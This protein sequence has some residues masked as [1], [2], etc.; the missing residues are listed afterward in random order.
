MAS[1]SKTL[2]QG[3][4]LFTSPTL[5]EAA[6]QTGQAV[7]PTSPLSAA[8]TGASKDAS[9]MVGTPAQT[10]GLS[11]V[12][13]SSPKNSP[14]AAPTKAP[15]GM[16]LQ[17]PET[18]LLDWQDKIKQDPRQLTAVEQD[19]RRQAEEMNPQLGAF[20]G[21]VAQLSVRAAF[22]G[23]QG[24]QVQ[25]NAPA[26]SEFV[27]S[28][29]S[30]REST[31]QIRQEDFTKD[32]A[33]LAASPGNAALMTKMYD[34]Y[35]IDNPET[36]AELL[37]S[38]G[39]TEAAERILNPEAVTM[40]KVFSGMSPEQIQTET[41]LSTSEL[42]KTFGKEWKSLTW[43]AMKDT[44]A[45][46][47][48]AATQTREL[49]NILNNPYIGAAQRSDARK[50]LVELGAIGVRTAEEKINNLK[51]QVEDGD[52]LVVDGKSYE[53]SEI[54]SD[55]YLSSK[56]TEAA[57]DDVAL[58]KLK[59]WAPEV[60]DWLVKNRDSLKAATAQVSDSLKTV[61]ED[62]AYNTNL[63]TITLGNGASVTLDDNLMKAF[64]PEWGTTVTGKMQIED[65]VYKTITSMNDADKAVITESLNSIAKAA[66]PDQLKEYMAK[67]RASGNV[68]NYFRQN[69]F[70]DPARVS[71]MVEKAHDLATID[72]SFTENPDAF[73]GGLFA[74][75][76]AALTKNGTF[77]EVLKSLTTD[78]F[79]MKGLEAAGL[80]H[81]F[82]VNGDGKLSLAD[83]SDK[84]KIF[85]HLK[86]YMSAGGI[87]SGTTLS[88]LKAQM[89]KEVVLGRQIATEMQDD[90]KLNSQASKDITAIGN[91][92]RGFASKMEIDT[93]VINSALKDPAS[94]NTFVNKA[95]AEFKKRIMAYRP[96]TKHIDKNFDSEINAQVELYKRNLESNFKSR[97]NKL[98]AEKDAAYAD[99]LRKEEAQSKKLQATHKGE[100]K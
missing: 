29:N 66:S 89:G 31:N 46:T 100:A 79:L 15:A 59:G 78:P 30:A 12:L 61:K 68:A 3:G 73:L 74:S 40:D 92:E 11:D 8:T 26:V 77:T 22:G 36:L 23:L 14:Q 84:R 75:E 57:N 94:M 58:E 41:G 71:K 45:K 48:P 56:I 49:T 9:K 72:S 7:L 17:L 82:D 95:T 91:Q 25:V 63:N 53:L 98:K 39:G 47:A 80:T 20:A 86:G 34:K 10:K 1:L 18:K 28:A 44:L 55:D 24:N 87:T 42:E 37:T 96:E 81:E 52:N 13:N 93:D 70:M 19:V 83:F 88:E 60:A 54:L 85:N 76:G 35:K 16:Q 64:S 27:T 90:E 97:M 51:A 5:A 6:N 69:G 33:A 99:K 67:A 32:L 50:S 65:P 4:E 43:G 38:A 2:K 21:R 62:Q